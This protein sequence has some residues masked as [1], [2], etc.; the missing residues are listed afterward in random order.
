MSTRLQKAQSKSTRPMYRKAVSR[1]QCSIKFYT[2]P[3]Y[4]PSHDFV[5]THL[6]TTLC[7]VR[8]EKLEK[9]REKEAQVKRVHEVEAQKRREEKRAMAS[10]KLRLRKEKLK[11]K[12]R[13]NCAV[14]SAGAHLRPSP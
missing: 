4:N 10:K 6:H 11:S 1:F 14:D 7:R 2:S 3:F 5:Q 13:R 9:D 8:A 12:V